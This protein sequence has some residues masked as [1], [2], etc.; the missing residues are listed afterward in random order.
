MTQYLA[1]LL[2]EH[3]GVGEEACRGELFDDRGPHVDRR[4]HRGDGGQCAALGANPTDPQAAPKRF[5]HRPD[6]QQQVAS[7]RHE[8]SHRRRHRPVQP[9]VGDRLVDDCAS[10]GFGDDGAEASATRFGKRHAGGIVVVDDQVGQVGGELTHR[11]VDRIEFPAF[12]GHGDGY[13]SCP[14]RRD[15]RQRAVVGGLLDQNPITGLG[16]GGQNQS[17]R[18]QRAGRHH[19]LVGLGG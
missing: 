5:R 17:D 10:A 3:V 9:H 11:G 19:D 4:A 16:V 6:R 1:P 13:R 2:E 15:G 14:S 12:V 7:G 18:V 8:G